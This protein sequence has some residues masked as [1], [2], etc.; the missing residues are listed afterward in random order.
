MNPLARLSLNQITTQGWNM[1]Q[2][3]EGCARAEI[4]YVG[5]WRQKIDEFGLKP[6]LRLLG[7][8]N[9]QVSSLCRGGHFPA[10]T[11]LAY[12]AN[13]DDNRRAIEMAAELGTTTLVLVCGAAPDKNLPQARAII[14][15]AIAELEP[16]AAQHHVKLGIEPLHPIFA[17]DRSAIV[18]LEQANDIAM[19]HPANSVGVVIDAYHVWW[20]PNIEREI[21]R[22]GSRII[23]FHIDDWLEPM[24]DQYL[25]RGMM[26]DGVINLRGLR[27]AIDQAGYCGPIEV[28]IFNQA[29][30]DSSGNQVLTRIKQ[31]YLEHVLELSQVGT[32]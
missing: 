11:E 27:R 9:L 16:F 7:E 13:L 19:Q 23:G 21:A 20:D 24:P 15:K 10:S 28:E 26:G 29:L 5:L 4:P 1:R 14:A 32:L 8:L 2:A 31:S 6:T 18:T 12:N 22:A 25:G 17:A 30:W 3:L